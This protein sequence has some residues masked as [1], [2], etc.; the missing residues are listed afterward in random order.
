M[1]NK[2]LLIGVSVALPLVFWLAH[3]Q[4]YSEGRADY[5]AEHDSALVQAQ[6]E[7]ARK[8]AE[9]QSQILEIEKAWLNDDAEKEIVYRD[10]VE[11][12]VKTVEKHVKDGGLSDCRIDDDS[13]HKINTALSGTAKASRSE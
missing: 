11:T 1:L 13:L 9:K 7:A 6:R 8:L 4:G 2:W 12:V 5:K 10:R 3:S